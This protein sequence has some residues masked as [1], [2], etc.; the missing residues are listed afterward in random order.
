VISAPGEGSRA[1]VERLLGPEP[2]GSEVTL[3]GQSLT[4]AGENPEQTSDGL[5]HGLRLAPLLVPRDGRYV[6]DLP[7]ASAAIV[8]IS[9]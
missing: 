6:V 8:T 2:T 4:G 7:A 5:L 1:T 3:G 9:R